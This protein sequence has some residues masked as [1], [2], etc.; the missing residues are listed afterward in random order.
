W[1]PACDGCGCA[2]IAA[3][4]HGRLL[5]AR[6]GPAALASFSL[7]SS[8]LPGACDRLASLPPELVAPAHAHRRPPRVSCGPAAAAPPPLP[9]LP[10]P[11]RRRL[12]PRRPPRPPL[13]RLPLARRL[14]SPLLPRLLLPPAPRRERPR[15]PLLRPRATRSSPTGRSGSTASCRATL[16][17]RQL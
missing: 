8:R 3:S 6:V 4:A 1:R 16:R 7:P 2:R 14:H 11:W 13:L 5:A 15:P 10:Q 9:L 17:T 12:P